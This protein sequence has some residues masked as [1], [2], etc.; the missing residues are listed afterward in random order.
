[1]QSTQGML[2]HKT[3]PSRLGEVAVSPNSWKQIHKDK[4]NEEAEEYVSNERITPKET[5]LMKLISNL[6]DKEFKIMVLKML[7]KLG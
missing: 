3:M 7:T 4:Q 2:L 6:P 5:T 1:M